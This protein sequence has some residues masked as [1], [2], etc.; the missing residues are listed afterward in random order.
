MSLAGRYFL[1]AVLGLLVIVNVVAVASG[2]REAG[3]PI[4][5][6][7]S[8]RSATDR[9]TYTS[10]SPA[11]RKGGVRVG[12]VLDTRLLTLSE[13]MTSWNRIGS[14]RAVVSFPLERNGR[15]VYARQAY[16][17]LT[18]ASEFSDS[19]FLALACVSGLCGLIFLVRGRDAP[20]LA[21]G[22]MLVSFKFLP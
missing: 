12:D 8:V 14:T 6:G 2:A 15:I 9:F 22:I 16:A 4:P 10:A 3:A 13:R 20:S 17:P 18:A 5:L 21:A 11:G 7:Q 1:A 19:L